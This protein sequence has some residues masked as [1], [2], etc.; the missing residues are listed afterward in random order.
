[1]SKKDY[2]TVVLTELVDRKFKE[3]SDRTRY[4]LKEK[5]INELLADDSKTF[6]TVV[7]DNEYDLDYAPVNANSIVV[8]KESTEIYYQR[9]DDWTCNAHDGKITFLSTGD[10]VAGT[11]IVVAYRYFD[12]GAVASDVFVLDTIVVDELILTAGQ[13]TKYADEIVFNS[14]VGDDYEK[15]QVELL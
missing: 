6:T 1:M 15:E 8:Y 7:L 2:M 5:I 9:Y 13:G 4:A 14:S 12:V 10:I 3:F 11:N